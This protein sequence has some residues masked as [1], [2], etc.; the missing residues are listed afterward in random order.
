LN[1]KELK[2][3]EKNDRKIASQHK[4][5]ARLEKKKNSVD[6]NKTEESEIINEDL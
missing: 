3:K 4:K 1:A 6:V 5:E 2:A